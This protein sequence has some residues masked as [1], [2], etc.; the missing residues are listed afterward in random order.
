MKTM[1]QKSDLNTMHRAATATR[2][3]LQRHK[4][5][6]LPSIRIEDTEFHYQH[7]HACGICNDHLAWLTTD[8]RQS[9]GPN[10]WRVPQKGKSL[11]NLRRV[12]IRN[13][14]TVQVDGGTLLGNVH[15]H[16]G[17]SFLCFVQG[18]VRA[19]T[20]HAEGGGQFSAPTSSLR[21]ET[22]Q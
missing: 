5:S 10:S 19:S 1:D 14:E 18:G 15:R 12:A 11:A 7:Q 20:F 22:D 2:P 17:A 13:S 9:A 3:Q 4:A 21:A 6:V 16:F 8:V